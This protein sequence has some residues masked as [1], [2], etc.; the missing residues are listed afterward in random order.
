MAPGWSWSSAKGRCREGSAGEGGSGGPEGE[1]RSAPSQA[2][3]WSRSSAG[4]EEE[5]GIDGEDRGGVDA[6]GDPHPE[7]P[8]PSPEAAL[9]DARRVGDGVRRGGH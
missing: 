2:S 8:S 4:L 1:E 9:R 6:V 3:A 7:G 5:G